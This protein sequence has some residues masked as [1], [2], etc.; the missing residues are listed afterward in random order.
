MPTDITK[1]EEIPIAQ[2]YSIYICDPDWALV[3]T[4][5]INST[6]ISVIEHRYEPEMKQ[7][8]PQS[9]DNWKALVPYSHSTIQSLFFICPIFYWCIIS[10]HNGEICCYIFV[11]AQDVTIKLGQCHSL[12]FSLFFPSF[13]PTFFL[14]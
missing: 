9:K 12:V 14:F 3:V 13:L 7:N 1:A 4:M 11:Y 10:V 8:K 2:F 5:T 6:I